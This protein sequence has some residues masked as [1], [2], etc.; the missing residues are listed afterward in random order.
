MA[1]KNFLLFLYSKQGNNVGGGE[2]GEDLSM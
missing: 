1:L 2:D